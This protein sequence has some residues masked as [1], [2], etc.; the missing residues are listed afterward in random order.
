M[1]LLG[2]WLRKY[3]A[4]LLQSVHS[5]TAVRVDSSDS[6]R[7]IMSAQCLMAGFYQPNSS[8]I[9]KNLFNWHPVPVHVVPKGN[10]VIIHDGYFRNM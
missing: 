3:F 1:F 2:K 6:D 4:E 5:H 9:L 8:Q 7:T 10:N